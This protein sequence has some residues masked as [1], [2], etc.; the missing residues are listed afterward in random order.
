MGWWRPRRLQRL[1]HCALLRSDC[2]RCSRGCALGRSR[3]GA[4]AG[5]RQLLSQPPALLPVIH[6]RFSPY[7]VAPCPE[8]AAVAVQ[9]CCIWRRRGVAATPCA[10]VA[11]PPPA[12]IN[13]GQRIDNAAHCLSAISRSV[14][15][16]IFVAIF[17]RDGARRCKCEHDAFWAVVGGPDLEEPRPHALSFRHPHRCSH[18]RHGIAGRYH[19]G[20]RGGAAANRC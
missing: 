2:T 10:V 7:R 13:G 4:W 8:P 6:R 3:D 18:Q 16:P 14:P 12:A 5:F 15:C 20:G 17:V 1:F 19:R 9:Q 11:A